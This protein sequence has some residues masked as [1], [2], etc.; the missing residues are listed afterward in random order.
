MS[1]LM[2]VE[3]F[4]GRDG[5]TFFAHIVPLETGVLPKAREYRKKV[6]TRAVRMDGP[7]QVAT[8]E[9]P[10]MCRDGWLCWDAR[11]YPYPVSADEFE[12]IYEEI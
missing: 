7:F 4:V 1:M 6:S 10:L 9:G 2:R 3:E 11:G 5:S 8:S 12:M